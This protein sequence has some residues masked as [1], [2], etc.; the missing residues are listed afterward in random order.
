MDGKKDHGW[1]EQ[2]EGLCP[3]GS[4]GKEVREVAR[5]LLLALEAM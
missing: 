4:G 3:L 5:D 1:L 2:R